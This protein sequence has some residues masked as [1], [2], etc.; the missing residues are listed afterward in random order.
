[1]VPFSRDNLDEPKVTALFDNQMGML[2]LVKSPR[3]VSIK[4]YTDAVF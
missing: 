3:K 4:I 2:I 1:M